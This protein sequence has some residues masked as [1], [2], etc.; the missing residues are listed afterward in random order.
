MNRR[1]ILKNIGL[2]TAGVI[3]SGEAIGQV[4]PKATQLKKYLRHKMASF[5]TK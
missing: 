2:G 4:K 3:V 5:V 1:D